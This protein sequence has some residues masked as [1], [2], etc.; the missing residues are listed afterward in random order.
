FIIQNETVYWSNRHL[1]YCGQYLIDLCLGGR[2]K[3]K[4]EKMKN[5]ISKYQNIKGEKFNNLVESLFSSF[6]FLITK[7]QVKKI[8]SKRIEGEKGDLGDI[9]VLVI[10]ARAKVVYVLECKDLSIARNPYEV[11]H[12]LNNLFVGTKKKPSIVEKHSRRTTWIMNNLDF[13]LSNYGVSTKGKWVVKPLVVIDEEMISPY[14]YKEKKGMR[15]ISFNQLKEELESGKFL[16][17]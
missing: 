9:D 17:N 14:L 15:V 6:E 13:M 1:Y 11:H 12:E 5:L 8:G 2:L 16:R 4:S 7:S 3:A 10:N